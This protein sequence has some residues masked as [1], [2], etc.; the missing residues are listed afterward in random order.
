[1]RIDDERLTFV[2]ITG[3][4]VDPELNRA[5]VFFDSLAGE[6]GDDGDPRGARRAP[7]PTAG[8]DRPADPG[9]EDADPRLPTRHGDP[10]G[11]AHR[12]ILR[13]D[14]DRLERQERRDEIGDRRT[15]R[16]DA[17]SSNTTD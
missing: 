8:V 11:G 10:L 2:S 6:E 3:I 17:T 15:D 1:M 7:D 4:D 12:R 14:R 13:S 5:I 9:Q 16:R